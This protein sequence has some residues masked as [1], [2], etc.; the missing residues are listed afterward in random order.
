[1]IDEIKRL[2]AL[3]EAAVNGALLNTD[4]ATARIVDDIREHTAKLILDIIKMHKE[5]ADD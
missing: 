1:V 3:H 4:Q 5:A 2:L